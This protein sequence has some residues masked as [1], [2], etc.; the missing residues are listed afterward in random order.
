MLKAISSVKPITVTTLIAFI[1]I[2]TFIF[3]NQISS[4]SLKFAK[5]CTHASGRLSPV[6]FEGAGLSLRQPKLVAPAITTIVTQTGFVLAGVTTVVGFTKP[7]ESI[8][9]HLHHRLERY[10]S[11]FVDSMPI[12]E[13]S[14]EF[15]TQKIARELGIT[16]SLVPRSTEAAFEPHRPEDSVTVQSDLCSLASWRHLQSYSSFQGRSPSEDKLN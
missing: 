6:R 5:L 8:G 1:D 2:A 12:V 11:D 9:E 13:V 16:P 10:L 7:K 14:S 3:P 15:P 4:D